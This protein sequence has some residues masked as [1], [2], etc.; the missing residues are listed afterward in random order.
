[1]PVLGYF[2]DWGLALAGLPVLMRHQRATDTFVAAR[3]D[4][5]VDTQRAHDQRLSSIDG[6][7][8]DLGAEGDR[9]NADAEAQREHGRRLDDLA[10]LM[11][12]LRA[13]HEG[14]GKV[15][16]DSLRRINQRLDELTQ[17]A[18]TTR[19]R[20]QMAQSQ[21]EALHERGDALEGR[22]AAVEGRA[23]ALEG[24]VAPLE[25]RV[26]P[27]EGRL[28]PLESRMAPLEASTAL[29]KDR[30]EANTSEM[31]EL[32]HYVHAANHWIVSMQASLADL[33]EAAT[34]EREQADALMALVDEDTSTERASR[35]A[36]WAA[37][38]GPV[39]PAAARV[40]DLGS[41]DGDWL[42]AMA[43]H[44]VIAN[45]IEPN[46]ALAA[47]ARARDMQVA[48]GDPLTTLSRCKDADLD[49]ITL[50]AHLLADD[51]VLVTSTLAQILRALKPAGRVMLRVETP[52]QDDS[53]SAPRRAVPDAQRWAALLAAAGFTH[54]QVLP[55][56]GA[57]AVL[58]QRA[59]P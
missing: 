5:A 19:N 22:A 37:K 10:A 43:I 44:G 52:P 4:A 7:I 15:L 20:S 50:A 55:A 14:R 51:D 42:A 3:F 45:G 13:E 35:H 59:A 25:S 12:T 2:M 54:A 27:L 56:H 58:A 6:A 30:H 32:R 53:P 28:A 8:A 18:E 48:S 40:L 1:M 36:D 31:I 57:A 29:L 47:R 46:K 41:G 38:L 33:E 49:A 23:F 11:T 16:T 24:R 9:R 26:A 39:L 21:L 34:T 17:H